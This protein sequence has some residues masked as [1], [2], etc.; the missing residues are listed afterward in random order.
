MTPEGKGLP[1][2]KQFSRKVFQVFYIEIFDDST[3]SAMVI[4]IFCE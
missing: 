3:M 2:F 1:F 4:L